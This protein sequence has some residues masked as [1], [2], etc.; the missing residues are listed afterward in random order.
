MKYEV[1]S[2]YDAL[3][4]RTVL[5]LANI[6]EIYSNKAFNIQGGAEP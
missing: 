5:K 3:L 4:R 1:C 2:D 6:K